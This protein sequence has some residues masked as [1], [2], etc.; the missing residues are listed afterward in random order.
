MQISPMRIPPMR[1]RHRLLLLLRCT[2]LLLFARP[3]VGQE[4]TR[5][6]G[7]DGSGQSDAAGIPV[8]WTCKDYRWRVK[9][10]GIGHSSPVVW[11]GRIFV[12][13]AIEEDA[14]QIIRCLDT[15]QGGLIWK[16]QFESTTYKKNAYNSYAAATPVVDKDH[17]YMSWSTPK[18]Y[19]LVA[20]DQNK[21]QVVWCR[22]LGPYVARHGFGASPILFEDM[23][24]VPNDQLEGSSA[25]AVDRM[26]GQ[27][28]WETE[29]PVKIAGYA[30]PCIY[31]PG[32]G[33]VQLILSGS[34]YGFISLDPRTG[35]KNW[36]IEVFPARV[37]GSPAIAAGL[38]FG[39]CGQGG[40][41]KRLVAVRPG[42]AANG[43]KPELAYDNRKSMPYVPTPVARGDLLF[44]LADSGIVTCLDAPTGDI[45]WQQRIGGNYFSSPVRAGDRIYCISRDGEMVVLAAATEYKLLGRINLEERSHST[46]AIADGV[47]YLRTVSHLM[48]VGGK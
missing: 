1:H 39:N 13:C 9:L 22:N 14:T 44:L 6:R 47:M 48:A 45:H 2:L 33:T 25:I 42:T 30:T 11:G 16:R 23:V 28:R 12:T 38:I 10:P 24:I 8:N 35:R 3:A 46:P 20:L 31:R 21:G 18:E 7:P 43:N 27:T 26:T 36:E 17:V 15:S 32:D 5:F 4:W 34:E 37:V 41:G 29:V 40:G 19:S